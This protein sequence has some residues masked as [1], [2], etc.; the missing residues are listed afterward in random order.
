VGDVESINGGASTDWTGLVEIG[1]INESWSIEY[2]D[3]DDDE[4]VNVNGIGDATVVD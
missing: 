4:D 2:D 3:G 1:I